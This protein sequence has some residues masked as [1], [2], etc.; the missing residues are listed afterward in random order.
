RHIEQ[1]QAADQLEIGI[2]HRLRDHERE[3]HPQQHGD[4]GAEDHAPEPLP[5]RQRHASHRDDDGV[6][7]GEDDVNADDR[8]RRDPERRVRHVLPQKIHRLPLFLSRRIPAASPQAAAVAAVSHNL[9][10]NGDRWPAFSSGAQPHG[11]PRRDQPTT[12]LPEKNWAISWAA[13][14]GASEPCTE[15]SPIDLAWTLRI[16]FGAALAGSVAPMMSRYLAMAFSPSSTWTTTGPE[17]MNA[18]SSP[19][20]GRALCTA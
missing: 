10:A 12:S 2:A 8:K 15:F 16:V 20:N 11:Q 17:I 1:Q 14:S 19:K 3:Q 7:A 4:T 6:V 13:V 18:T 5:R 9:H